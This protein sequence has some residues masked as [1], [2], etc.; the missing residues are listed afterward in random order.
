MTVEALWSNKISPTAV[1]PVNE[2]ARTASDLHK[3]F[4][5]SADSSLLAGKTHF[6]GQKIKP[7]MAFAYRHSII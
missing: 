1:E 4:P 2:I 5:I 3:I 7:K 6:K